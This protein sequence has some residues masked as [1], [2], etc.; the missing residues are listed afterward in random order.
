MFLAQ[1]S[2]KLPGTQVF[3]G[4][5]LESLSDTICGHYRLHLRGFATCLLL[6]SLVDQ[7]PHPVAEDEAPPLFCFEEMVHLYV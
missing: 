3:S 5:S 6:V 1:K 2:E 7:L 4:L